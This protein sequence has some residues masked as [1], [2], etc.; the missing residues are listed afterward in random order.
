MKY[1]SSSWRWQPHIGVCR[2]LWPLL[3]ARMAVLTDFFCKMYFYVYHRAAKNAGQLFFWF[4]PL[5]EL[6]FS[7]RGSLAV[8]ISREVVLPAQEPP[9]WKSSAQHFWWAEHKLWSSV[10]LS[11]FPERWFCWQRNHLSG[12][13]LHSISDGLSIDHISISI[14]WFQPPLWKSGT[15][16]L[17]KW[18][19]LR[20]KVSL[21]PK[22]SWNE[23]PQKKPFPDSIWKCTF[24]KK[25]HQNW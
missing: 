11:R 23:V 14:R 3:R 16:Y 22:K 6:F 1:W 19:S 10:W 24:C 13:V 12:K 25:P 8:Q 2:L 9:L 20:K 5:K 21:T 4:Y 18:R 17:E 7:R 15:T